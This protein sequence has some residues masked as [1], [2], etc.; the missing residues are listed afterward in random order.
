MNVLVPF[1]VSPVSER[2]VR[3][4]LDVLSG[5]DDVHITAVHISGSENQPA[6]IAASEIESMG[7]DRDVSVAADVRVIEDADGGKPAIRE[8]ITEIIEE[9]AID[10]VVLGHE[11]KSVFEQVFRSDT[12]ERVLE[13]YELPVLTVP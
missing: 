12:T 8:A 5:H 2:A 3:T 4:A 10:L 11:K 1:D 9:E 6:E 13:T 7:A